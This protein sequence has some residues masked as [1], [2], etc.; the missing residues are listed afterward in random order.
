LYLKNDV[1]EM[2]GEK[3]LHDAILE[4]RVCANTDFSLWTIGLQKIAS[5]LASPQP[6]SCN[7]PPIAICARMV[8]EQIKKP[9][10]GS[11]GT[12]IL[13]DVRVCCC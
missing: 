9:L 6:T 5:M 13:P 4:L 12:F 2:R 7:K 1:E 10:P 8:C 11:E 3:E